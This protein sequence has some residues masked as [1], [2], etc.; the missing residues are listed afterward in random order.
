MKT[1]APAALAA[2]NSRAPP[3]SLREE[4]RIW[5]GRL[6]QGE[7][8]QMDMQA[9]KRW[10]HASPD[11]ERAFDEAKRGWHAMRPAIG[12]LLR[13]DPKIAAR[14]ERLLHG[15]AP[16][17]RVF[18][19]AAASAAAVAGVAMLYPPLGLWPSPDE[20]RADERT[21]TGEQRTLALAGQ[22]SVTLNTQTSVRRQMAG[23]EVTG[24]ELIAGEAAVDAPAGDMP[25]GV[26]AGAGRSL[27]E[28]AGRFQVRHLREEKVC[29]TC[30]EGA[31]R[32]EHPAGSRTL[33][34][35][36]QL[37]YGPAA[38][39]GA[40]SI[41]PADLSAWRKGGLVF[42]QTPLAQVV[43]EI[44]RYRPGRVVLM[45]AS[46]R[47]R[48]VS[49]RFAIAVLDEALLQIQHSFDLSARALPGGLLILS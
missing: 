47:E 45:A 34:A 25:F 31:V 32:V 11:H 9:F 46:K 12:E 30:L 26:A 20:W 17:R 22:I 38:I 16:G 43:D 49:G 44:N 14:H 33:R 8:T 3:E 5:L 42:R 4:A 2:D 35:R 21:A 36:Q 39:G 27:A 10:R 18:L 7:V 13:A 41:E 19:G 48:A 40:A 24:I 1:S 37:V 6:A 23:G 28:G 29:V 15:R